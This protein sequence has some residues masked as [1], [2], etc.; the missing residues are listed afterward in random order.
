MLV[1]THNTMVLRR[2]KGNIYL[3]FLSDEIALTLSIRE[4]V[5][6]KVWRGPTQYKG[7]SESDSFN[8]PGAKEPCFSC[9]CFLVRKE[10]LREQFTKMVRM[11]GLLTLT[12]FYVLV[13]MF[14]FVDCRS[15]IGVTHGR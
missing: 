9:C 10:H 7:S 2:L 3:G 12:I 14:M 6:R 11:F 1:N 8:L 15:T 4:T 5:T 13:N